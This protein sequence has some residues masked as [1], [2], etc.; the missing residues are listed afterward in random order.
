MF[1]RIITAVCLAAVLIPVAIFSDTAVFPIAIA[2][3]SGMGCFE[4]LRCIGLHKNWFLTVPTVLFG[5]G[6]PFA[7]FY[8]IVPRGG[9]IILPLLLAA[10]VTLAALIFIDLRALKR[11]RRETL[12]ARV[13]ALPV[14]FEDNT[15]ES[16]LAGAEKERVAMLPAYLDRVSA[17]DADSLISDSKASSLIIR[18]EI[19]PRVCRG[20]KKTFIN[21]DTLSESFERGETVT[22]KRLKE[23]GLVPMSACYVKV[24]ARGV[25]DKPLTVRAQGFSAN[26][27]KMITLTG[28]TAILEGSERE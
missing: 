28:G 3:L 1:V 21:A 19:A 2:L 10:D 17:E 24:L 16:A 25:I 20:C 18:S 13:Y 4:M 26:A 7:A 5:I 8:V 12:S 15:D 6:L 22:I 11:A 14:D 23:R 27:V 9:A